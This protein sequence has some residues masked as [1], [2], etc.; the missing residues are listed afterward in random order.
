M[1]G[2]KQLLLPE[3]TDQSEQAENIDI[4]LTFVGQMGQSPSVKLRRFHC[5][6]RNGVL[7]TEMAK[8]VQSTIEACDNRY[9]MKILCSVPKFTAD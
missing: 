7:N 5:A 9:K 6:L 2:S 3:V 4:D 8:S 1:T